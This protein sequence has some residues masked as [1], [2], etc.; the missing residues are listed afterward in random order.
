MVVALYVSMNSGEGLCL[1]VTNQ[2]QQ[3]GQSV[4]TDSE[5][6]EDGSS[7]TDDPRGSVSG[8]IHS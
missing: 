7:V 1:G 2:C 3:V 5:N 8:D 4:Q 6:N